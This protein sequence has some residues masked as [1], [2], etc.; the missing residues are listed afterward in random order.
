MYKKLRFLFVLS[1]VGIVLLNYPIIAQSLTNTKI[2]ELYT[3]INKYTKLINDQFVYVD[4]KT[5][6][7]F[8]IKNKKITKEFVISTGKNGSGFEAVSGS[9]KTPF[10]LLKI[11]NK[12]G[13]GADIGQVFKRK[14]ITDKTARIYKKGDNYPADITDDVTTRL[15]VLEGCE[16]GINKGRNKN[17]KIV[18][19]FYR[20]IYI[21]GTNNESALGTPASH[22]CIRLY[23]QEVIEL[24]N[25]V[26]VGTLV[27]IL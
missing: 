27:L 24:F 20:A 3:Y 13:E 1:L 9:G 22:G 5:Q 17:N 23:N 6:T 11:S 8:I 2:D 19:T 26:E 18:D 4:T 14:R 25:I 12:I 7:M 10:G 21:H 15:L 16:P